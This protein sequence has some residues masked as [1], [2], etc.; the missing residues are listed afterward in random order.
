MA[1][2]LDHFFILSSPGAPEADL[3]SEFGLREGAPNDHQGQ[4]TANRRFFF[5]NAMLEFL[6]MHNPAEAK[7]G[8]ARRLNLTERWASKTASPFGLIVSAGSD[9]D[10]SPFAGWCYD[11]AYLGAGESF[12]IGENSDRLKEPLCIANPFKMD[13]E[14][15]AVHSQDPPFRHVFELIISVPVKRPSKVLQA[16]AAVPLVTLRLDAPHLMEIV[17]QKGGRSRRTDMRPTLPLVLSW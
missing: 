14:R 3:L 10:G 12:L 4:G 16:L 5:A 1:A 11:P 13:R 7:S 15:G 9:S 2:E 6:Y 17:F 8:F